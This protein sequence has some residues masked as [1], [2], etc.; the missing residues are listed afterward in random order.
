MICAQATA[1]TLIYRVEAIAV[2]L[3]VRQCPAL[4]RTAR[5]VSARALA[6]SSGRERFVYFEHLRVREVILQIR[7]C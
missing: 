1:L 7:C 2:D 6:I 4:L 5:V 3:L